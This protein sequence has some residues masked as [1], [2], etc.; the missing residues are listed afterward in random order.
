MSTPT[1]PAAVLFHLTSLKNTVIIT[2]VE[3]HPLPGVSKFSRT[4]QLVARVKEKAS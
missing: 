1:V 3:G 4:T 2:L